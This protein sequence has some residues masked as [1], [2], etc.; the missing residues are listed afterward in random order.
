MSAVR[1]ALGLPGRPA[2]YTWVGPRN[3]LGAGSDAGWVVCRQGLLAVV[4]VGAAVVLC[5]V[6]D[7]EGAAA[8]GV[9]ADPS[10]VGVA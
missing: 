10:D 7:V 4:A 6:C 5:A 1:D 3:L 9:A 8:L 2:T